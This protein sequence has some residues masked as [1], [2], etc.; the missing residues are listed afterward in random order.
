MLVMVSFNKNDNLFLNFRVLFKICQQKIYFDI[1]EVNFNKR[2]KVIFNPK[3]VNYAN[4]IKL[5]K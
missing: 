3:F 1:N 4:N 2:R 5:I